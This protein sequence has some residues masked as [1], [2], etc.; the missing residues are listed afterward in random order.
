MTASRHKSPLALFG[1][2]VAFAAAPAVAQV[3]A[4]PPLPTRE[5]VNRAAP[6]V[7]E[8]APS[9]LTIAGG[10]ERAPCPLADP[11]FA[12]VKVTLREALFDNLQAVPAEALRPAY[13][14]YLGREMPIAVVC[15][16]RDAAAT[17]LRRE[18]YLAAVQVP[19][20]KITDGTIHF[21]V[22][23][24]KVVAIQVRGDAGRSERLI[25]GYLEALKGDAVFNERNAERYLLLARDLPGYDVRLT[26]RP[27]GTA[28]GDVIG[29]VTVIKTP[30]TIEA[31]VQ[32]YGS[33]SVGR[34][35]AMVRGEAYD[36]LG[37][38]DRLT[39]GL[40][41]TPDFE[42]QQVVQLGYDM[43]LGREGLTIGGR[44]AYAWTEP[45]LGAGAGARLLSRTLVAAGEASYPFLRSQAANI[46]G[47]AGFELV[48][49]RARLVPDTGGS[50]PISE[51]RTRTLYV[52][53]DLQTMD[54]ASIGST[55]G[56]SV[57]EPRWR[58][59]GSI[60]LRKGIDIFGASD[61]GSVLLS[62]FDGKP[63][64]FLVRASA[65]GEYRPVPAI[66]VSLSPRAQYAADP[67]LGYEQFSGGNFT[68]GRGYDPGA[69]IGDSG[70]GF[71]AEL[72]YGRIAPHS[73]DDLVVQPY[74]FF[75][76]AWVWNKGA[77]AALAPDPQSLSSIGAGLR[78]AY[79]DHARI[80]LTV[81]APLR[82]APNDVKRRDPRILLSFSTRLLPW[83]R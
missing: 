48:N 34:F 82:R 27:A 41:S 67:L 15:E 5:E 28:P 83:S 35:G 53:L 44:F 61:A 49:Q 42:E 65:S 3:T 23:M 11:R 25:A 31:N 70:V 40:Y 78:G 66:T 56:Y 51:D 74:A 76:Q 4:P 62:R 77:L 6:D 7:V 50:I 75:D 8:R 32:N 21:N 2:T 79:G 36:L 33:R 20:Q 54:R 68:V 72:R 45:D 57:S 10:I 26:L 9:R 29:E 52:R 73:R 81:A 38:G 63:N 69:I 24:A 39:A 47:A 43:R 19:A 17:I 22:L 58:V 46:R 14:A 12:D 71:A 64:G 59:G 60:E 37:S 55:S 13:E 16:I 18:G 80:D 1:L 30:F